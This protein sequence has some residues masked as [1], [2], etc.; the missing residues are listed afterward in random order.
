M[1]DWWEGRGFACSPLC[2]AS[3]PNR[4][5]Q[6]HADP[7]P[8]DRLSHTLSAPPRTTQICSNSFNLIQIRSISFRS[9][10]PQTKDSL[11]SA[12]SLEIHSESDSCSLPQICS[13]SCSHTQTH[14][15]SPNFTESDPDSFKVVYIYSDPF[16]HTS[17]TLCFP[18]T[19][20]DSLSSIQ[21]TSH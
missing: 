3:D 20:S 13:D 8:R 4:L 11:R 2:L 21:I 5:T 14:S 1:P 6:S 16:S 15:G 10:Q 9:T 7:H 19:H 12:R 17:E 18:Q